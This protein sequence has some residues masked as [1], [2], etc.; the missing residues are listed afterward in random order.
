[1]RLVL[2]LSSLALSGCAWI[3]VASAPAKQASAPSAQGLA[4]AEQFWAVLHSG[5]YERIDALLETHMQVLVKEPG[6]ALTL[7]HT[8]W[9]H[10]WKFSERTRTAPAARIIEHA[11]AA[12][13][14]FDEAVLLAPHEARYRGFAAAFTM[15]EATI[16]QNQKQLRQG[17]FEMKD[18][19]AMWPEFNL[20]TS[21]YS[22]SS[23]PADSD[24]FREGLAQQWETLDRCF[25]EKV[26]R[27]SPRFDRYMGLETQ[28]GT[29]RVCWNSWIAPHNFEGFFLNFGDMLARSND[30]PN[31]RAM[32][33]ATR[34]SKT[35]A[36][37][38]YRDRLERRLAQLES[39]PAR[40]NA[41]PPGEAEWTPMVS[42][43]ISCM[44]C[45]QAR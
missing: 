27:T 10:A 23:A 22:M 35:Y 2:L 36:Q 41:A 37:W 18:A 20:F 25:N 43:S 17:Y 44:G 19:V 16:L 28:S 39:L 31:A 12:R 15:V 7:A 38:P 24:A 1:M 45:H 8:G 40:L 9:L 26:S 33:E 32:Y 14:Y 6:D 30:L 42:S 29:Q 34:L 21:G 13:R 5:Q 11:S 4:A 3:G